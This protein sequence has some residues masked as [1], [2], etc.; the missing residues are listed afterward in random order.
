MT[1]YH[2]LSIP[3]LVVIWSYPEQGYNSATG[4]SGRPEQST[5][6]HSFGTYI[7]NFQKHAQDI[8]SHVSASLT[9]TVLYEQR[10]LYDALV[11][12]VAMLLRLINCRFIII[13]Y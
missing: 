6:G 2:L 3:L 1:V 8:F 9:I 13:Y 12:T 10:T 11:V 7:I 5:T 4:W